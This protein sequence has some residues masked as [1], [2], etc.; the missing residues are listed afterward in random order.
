MD[1]LTI[2]ERIEHYMKK[3]GMNNDDVAK[4]LGIGRAA[5]FKYKKNPESMRYG[6]IKKMCELFH[7]RVETLLEGRR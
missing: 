3:Y 4:R 2:A 7:V 1:E 5:F 6:V